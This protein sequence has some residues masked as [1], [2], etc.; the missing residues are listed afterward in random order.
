MNAFK[1]IVTGGAGYI[2]SHVCK[3]LSDAGFLPITIDS[4]VDGHTWAV[5]W[6]PLEIGDISNRAFIDSIIEKYEPIA[7]MHF[8]AFAFVY[9]SVIDPG[10]YYRNNVAGTLNLLEAARDHNISKFVFSSTCAIYGEPAI[11]PISE[12]CP[13]IPVN[14]YGSSKSMI[15]RMLADF[16]YAHGL[17]SVSLRYFNAAGG[18]KEAEIG[19]CHKPETHIIPLLLDVAAGIRNNF[20][21]FGEDYSTPDGTCIRD[22]IHVKDLANAH[23][24][25]L[26]YLING[27]SSLQMNL[28]SGIGY[29]VKEII[30]T[31]EKITGCQI[32]IISGTRRNGDSAVLIADSNKAKK[33]LNWL[34]IHSGLEE[35]V[36]SAWD[37]HQ[38]KIAKF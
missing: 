22:Y 38:I 11:V 7:I 19:E 27:G 18:D 17:R 15:E 21:L 9:E 32:P 30:L 5:K 10:K 23:V 34:P 13:Q 35:I 16:D 36:K 28:G 33:L 2:G 1:I 29:S 37:W 6:G 4:L 14:P 25:S 24:S 26:N 31:V 12:N 20:T 8:A 3:A